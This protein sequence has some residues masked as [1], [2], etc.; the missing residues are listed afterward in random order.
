[1]WKCLYKNGIQI[2]DDVEDFTF[3][4]EGDRTFSEY[5][6]AAFQVGKNRRTE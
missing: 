5:F 3:V 6:A 2:Q 4:R 1:M